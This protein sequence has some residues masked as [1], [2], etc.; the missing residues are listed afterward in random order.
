MASALHLRHALG[1]G[2]LAGGG[3]GE[4]VGV[5][6]AQLQV[7]ETGGGGDAAV[8]GVGLL[9]RVAVLQGVNTHPGLIWGETPAGFTAERR[10]SQQQLKYYLN[11]GCTFDL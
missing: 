11:T 3:R 10:R 9:H 1:S 4:D 7:E 8:P 2:R 5:A 6:D